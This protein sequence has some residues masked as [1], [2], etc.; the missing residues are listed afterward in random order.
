LHD[1]VK[2]NG[3]LVLETPNIDTIWFKLLQ[4]KWR[5]LIPDHRYF[6]TPSTLTMLCERNGF[7]VE[8]LKMVG[9][10]MSLRLFVSRLGR[11]HRPA[12]AMLDKV[13]RKLHLEE[14]TLRLNLGDVM[15]LY[16]R[17]V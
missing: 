17:R 3:L 6:F 11:Y 7:Q 5:Q 16:A 10:S 9:K 8:E 2:A 15:R 1:V 13:I 14:K 12:A 4:G